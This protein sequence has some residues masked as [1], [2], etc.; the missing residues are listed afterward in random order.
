MVLLVLLQSFFLHAIITPYNLITMYAETSSIYFIAIQVSWFCFHACN[1][2]LIV[3]PC[4]QMQLEMDTTRELVSRLV[5]RSD[6]AL[7][8][9]LQVFYRVL[10]LNQPVVA[11]LGVCVLGRPL[12]VSVCLHIT[13]G[14]NKTPFLIH[15]CLI[16]S[17]A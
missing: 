1:V 10:T 17:L 5:R 2:V 7:S 6:A 9:A 16:L 4:H 13:Q 8:R 12:V 11:P 15:Y 3:E 14:Q